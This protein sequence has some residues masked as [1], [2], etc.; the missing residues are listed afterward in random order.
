L[1]VSGNLLSFAALAIAVA[2]SQH[3]LRAQWLYSSGT[4][5]PIYYNSGSV[6][7][8]TS[9]PALNPFQVHAGV[10]LNLGV[11]YDGQTGA[12]GLGAYNDAGTAPTPLGFNASQFTF[13]NGSVG[14]G[15]TSPGYALTVVGSDPSR[16]F[17]LDTSGTG[18]GGCC[19]TYGTL[20]FG[21]PNG[22]G[23]AAYVSYPAAVGY[24]GVRLVL[25]TL[26]GQG[27]RIDTMTLQ[28]G[29]VGI[30]TT[31][32]QH[33][34]HVAGTIGAEEIIVSATGAD[35]VFAP[36]YHLR[37][38]TEVAA[39]IEQNHHLPDIPS[40]AEVKEKGVSV[41]EME[42]KL[43]AKIEELTLHMIQADEQIRGLKEENR[44]LENQI[45]VITAEGNQK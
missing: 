25:Q 1:H 11:R 18:T 2:G 29:S 30:G 44:K 34:L 17:G 23:P 8:G 5:G 33:L 10:N 43:L 36:N 16:W 26:N 28:N 14:I 19:G 7:I 3:L 4:S 42:S 24:S 22:V 15:T 37:P 13:V 27:A 32:P 20:W 45:E 39:Y 6:A 41:G 35:Y 21:G 40:A 38:L 9:S 12:V 31:T